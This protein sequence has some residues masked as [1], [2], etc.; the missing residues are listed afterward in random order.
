MIFNFKY[1]ACDEL[2][3]GINE[4]KMQINQQWKMYYSAV[5]QSFRTCH[6][7]YKKLTEEPKGKST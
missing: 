2:R 4:Y 7:P 6:K 1:N 3:D 5:N